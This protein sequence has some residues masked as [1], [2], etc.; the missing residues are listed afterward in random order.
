[1]TGTEE[2]L[3]EET[4]KWSERLEERISEVEPMDEEGEMVL[5]NSE[6][7]LQDAEHF[8]EEGD[9]VRAFEAV[10]WGWAWLEIGEELRLV[11]R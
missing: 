1:M 7:Y 6:A 11:E 9:L 3:R 2:Q 8:E 10:V 4:G 5:E